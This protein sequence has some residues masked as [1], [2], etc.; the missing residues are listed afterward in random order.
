MIENSE[1]IRNV[2]TTLLTISRRKDTDIDIVS[3]MGSLVKKLEEKYSFL[4][5]VEIDDRRFFETGDSITVM[6][7]ID[8][9]PSAEMGKAIH[10]II[11]S[12]IELL[13]R[14]AGFYFIKEIGHRIGDDCYTTIR[15]DMGVNLNLMQLEWGASRMEK[16]LSDRFKPE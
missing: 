6:S 4:K 9:V 8:L 1:V 2:L 5:H 14:N 15:D 7:N 16:R 10:D 13:G 3:T 12:M 11:F